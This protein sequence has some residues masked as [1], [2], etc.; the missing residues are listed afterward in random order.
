LDLAD[1][2]MIVDYPD[3]IANNHE[4][5]PV[6]IASGYDGAAWTGTGLGS[7]T[8]AA[9]AADSTLYKTGLGY[10]EATDLFP[11]IPF[12]S[13]ATFEGLSIDS[14]ALLVKYTYYGDANLQGTVNLVDFGRLATNFG[15]SNKR[16]FDGDFNYDGNVGIPDFN[17]LATNFGHQ[18]PLGSGDSGDAEADYTYEQL[19]DMLENW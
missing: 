15:L 1:N 12:P 4:D 9:I 10:A 8:A 7:S 13:N 2:A 17:R 6:L 11:Q 19:E 3:G 18:P 5:V 16:W 14:T